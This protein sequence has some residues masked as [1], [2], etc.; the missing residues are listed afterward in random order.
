LHHLEVEKFEHE[1]ELL[2][3]SI[4]DELVLRAKDLLEMELLLLVLADGHNHWLR[5]HALQ[6]RGTI[7]DLCAHLLAS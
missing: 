1:D 5:V 4:N 7:F 3:D 6:N 2:A